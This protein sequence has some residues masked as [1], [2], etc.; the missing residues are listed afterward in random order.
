MICLLVD[1]DAGALDMA[2]ASSQHPASIMAGVAAVH[3]EDKLPMLAAARQQYITGGHKTT[4][5]QY[6]QVLLFM[7]QCEAPC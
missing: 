7:S 4:M 2:I 3:F 5:Q 6:I 1:A